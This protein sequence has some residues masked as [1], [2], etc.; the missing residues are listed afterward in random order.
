MDNSGPGVPLAT[1]VGD[2]SQGDK[3]CAFMKR[4]DP[5]H[6][7]LLLIF[8]LLRTTIKGLKSWTQTNN[9]KT[10]FDRSECE[11]RGPAAFAGAVGMKDARCAS[12]AMEG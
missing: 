1:V 10:C 7:C 4:F 2:I 6:S 8:L 3:E 5:C 11:T 12:L 9:G